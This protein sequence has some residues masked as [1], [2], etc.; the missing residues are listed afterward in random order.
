MHEEDFL[1]AKKITEEYRSIRKYFDKD[2]YNHG[3]SVFDPTSWAIFQYHDAETE[4]GIVMAFRREASPFKSVSVALEGLTEGKSY[5][6]ENM[7]DGTCF[8]L[9]NALDICLT[10]KRSSVIFEYSLS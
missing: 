1:W 9:E 10:E 4:S 7:N 6:F 5:R 2:F 8:T 3:S